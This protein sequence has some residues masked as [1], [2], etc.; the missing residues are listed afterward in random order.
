M[1]NVVL[2]ADG[3]LKFPMAGLW[4]IQNRKWHWGGGCDF[5]LSTTHGKAADII[6]ATSFATSRAGPGNS[7]NGAYINVT[8]RDED[9]KDFYK[10]Q[11][12]GGGAG[13]N[14]GNG[15]AR[16]PGYYYVWWRA[17]NINGDGTW[18]FPNTSGTAYIPISG[19]NTYMLP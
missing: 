15:N 1:T 19:A 18:V 9:L 16:H 12:T 10:F 4:E 17:R 6:G 2:R 5:K 11:L 8:V 14:C 7:W 13:F 3:L